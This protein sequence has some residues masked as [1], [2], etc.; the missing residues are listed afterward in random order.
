MSRYKNKTKTRI[1]VCHT[2]YHVYVSLLKEMELTRHTPKDKYKKA[3]I[4][5]SKMSM[6]FENLHERLRKTGF[7]GNVIILDEKHESFFPELAKY[8]KNYGNIIKHMVNR[9][10]FTKR[11]PKCEAPYMDKIGFEDYEDI[12]VYCDSDPIGYYL[13]YKHIYYHAVE[14]GLDCLKNL[15]DA[16]VANQGHFKFKAWCSRHN[17][18][19]I[20]NGWGKYCLD[21]EVNDIS[22]VPG[23]CPNIKE[24]PRK[25]ME[26]ALTSEQKEIMLRAFIEDYDS[27]KSQF[28]T[29]DE[30]VEFAMYLS[31]GYPKDEEIRKQVCLD[32]IAQHCRGYKVIIKPHPMD[33]IDYATLCPDAIV[34]RGRFPVEVLN[35]FEG[36]HVKKAV[37]VVST[38]MN[39]MDF[40]EEKLNLG[41][42]FWDKYE[43]A[44]KHSFNKKI[45]FAM[46]DK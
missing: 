15:D 35:F 46:A 22:K 10:I 2:Y 12:Y 21:M 3:D 17:L 39:N 5:L 9:M 28:V 24:V 32:V 34:L 33:K 41:V 11:L 14:D 40:V 38:A 19:F 6:D 42:S 20:M 18:I 45:G 30:N 44:D 37:A 27:L 31:E 8:R 25:P 23:K 26:T 29:A 36:L 16:Y 7:F 1:Y 43:D 4:A 13:N